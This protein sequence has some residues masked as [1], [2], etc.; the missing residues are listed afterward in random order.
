MDGG[1]AALQR[2]MKK[3]RDRAP[4]KD[5]LTAVLPETVGGSRLFQYFPYVFYLIDLLLDLGGFF[6]AGNGVD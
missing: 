6:N 2:K 3:R 1:V 5:P 4:D